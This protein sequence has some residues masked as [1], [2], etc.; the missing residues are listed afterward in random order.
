[1]LGCGTSVGVPM[2]GCHCAVCDGGHPRNQRTRSSVLLQ[3]PGGNLLIDTTPEMRLQLLREKIDCVNAV[4]YTHY[5]VDHLFGLDDCRVFPKFLGGALPLYCTD[6][7][8]AVIRSAFSYAFD[9]GTEDL[10]P[11][12][13][14]KLDFHRID[15]RPFTVLGETITPI[16]LMHSHF[17]VMGFRIGN[18]AYCTDVSLIPDTSLERLAGLDTLILDAL[19]PHRPHPS[20]F[21]IEQALEVFEQLKPRRMILTH[22]SHEIDYDT[23]KATLPVGV[24]PGYDGLTV[25]F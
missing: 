11:G 21:C 18:L 7:V 20:H 15:P 14:P 23:L 12:F 16:P 13:L 1:M 3:L 8:E 6:E 9:S 4:V 19:R 25:N 24:E 10:P 2:L 17:K 5:H 22:M